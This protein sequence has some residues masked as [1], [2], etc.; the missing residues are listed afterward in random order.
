MI[1]FPILV[2]VC[3]TI[4]HVNYRMKASLITLL[5][6]FISFH[7]PCESSRVLCV[8]YSRLSHFNWSEIEFILRF[9]CFFC[10][11]LLFFHLQMCRCSYIMVKK[12]V[13]WRHVCVYIF[14]M[15]W[16]SLYRTIERGSKQHKDLVDEKKELFCCFWYAKCEEER[17]S[18]L[19]H[20][21]LD[22]LFTW[23]HLRGIYFI[24]R[25]GEGWKFGWRDEKGFI[26]QN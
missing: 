5:I 25:V 2:T 3:E 20:V 16:I 17:K 14:F 6:L 22:K 18:I 15:W 26:S 11:L 8:C 7:P 12:H 24:K 10:S 9:F 1:L 23:L 19:Y 21:F 4:F 13:I